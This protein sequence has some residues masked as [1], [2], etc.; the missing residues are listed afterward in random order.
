MRAGADDD[1]GGGDE[2]R[3]FRENDSCN[4][5]YCDQTEP[6]R[7]VDEARRI[8]RGSPTRFYVRLPVV[9]SRRRDFVEQ[10]RR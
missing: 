6:R 10:T 5:A 1:D 2:E 3:R 7:H 8:P 4:G 9:A